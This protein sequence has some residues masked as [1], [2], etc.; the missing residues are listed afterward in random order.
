MLQR[1]DLSA[2]LAEAQAA[3]QAAASKAGSTVRDLQSELAHVR[4]SCATLE[5]QVCN[6]LTLR[7]HP[8]STTR[9]QPCVMHLL[10]EQSLLVTLLRAHV[11]ASMLAGAAS[12]GQSGAAQGCRSC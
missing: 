1:D 4:G 3:A 6:T 5:D 7:A 2:A 8:I 10:Q 9:A 12:G 11:Q